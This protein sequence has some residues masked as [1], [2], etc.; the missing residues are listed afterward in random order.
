MDQGDPLYCVLYGDGFLGF[1]EPFLYMIKYD[2]ILSM[3]I[4]YYGT[5]VVCYCCVV[6]M[7]ERG[8]SSRAAGEEQYRDILVVAEQP[9]G[10]GR[11]PAVAPVFP[12]DPEDPEEDYHIR[13]VEE[14]VRGRVFRTGSQD[15]DSE[16]EE[17][18]IPETEPEEP[19]EIAPQDDAEPQDSPVFYQ[20]GGFPDGMGSTADDI[21]EGMTVYQQELEERVE[22]LE[23]QN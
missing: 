7:I 16:S 5:D 22:H 15:S 4:F 3:N 6:R 19:E 11:M 10:A 17:D 8:E 14:P 1:I 13:E 9:Y 2:F 18:S 21:I 20:P 23:G 12:D